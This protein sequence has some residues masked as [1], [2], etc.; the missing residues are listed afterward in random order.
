MRIGLVQLKASG[1]GWSGNAALYDRYLAEAVAKGCSVVFFPELSDTGYALSLMQRLAGCWPGP[2]LAAVQEAARRHGVSVIAGLSERVG[3]RIFNSAAAVDRTGTLCGHYR[4]THLFCGPEGMERDVFTLG[5]RLETVIMDGVCWGLSICFDLRF[6]EV[7]RRLTLDGA[8]VLVNLAAWPRVRIA[9]W[10]ILCR[11]R[12]IENQV[13]MA[14][15][16]QCGMSGGNDFGG[17]SCLIGPGGDAI[18]VGGTEGDGLLT[19]DVD[20]GAIQRVRAILPVTTSR[21]PLL[22]EGRGG[23][24]SLSLP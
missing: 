12:A 16:N 13:F 15:V 7:Y 10:D 11:A 5:D 17:G 23:D 19:G 3:D 9:D 22:Y 8:Q 24:R 21:R 2:A 14:G 4:K 20:V 18:S 6:P 1:S